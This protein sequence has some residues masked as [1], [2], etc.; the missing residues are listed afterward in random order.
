MNDPPSPGQTVW[1]RS[2]VP[3]PQG[4]TDTDC[5]LSR[6]NGSMR[7]SAQIFNRRRVGLGPLRGLHGPPD[8]AAR[9]PALHVARTRDRVRG[10]RPASRGERPSARSARPVPA[11]VERVPRYRHRR[12]LVGIDGSPEAEE[13]LRSAIR[14]LGGRLGS[15]PPRLSDE[16]PVRPAFDLGDDAHTDPQALSGGEDRMFDR[17]G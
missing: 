15:E 17:I 3:S 16:R 5:A 9:P 1:R 11:A 13:A 4:R 2:M 12:G 14:M 7:D 10:A 6:G 8:G